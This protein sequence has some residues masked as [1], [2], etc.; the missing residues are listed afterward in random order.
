[1]W[2]SLVGVEKRPIDMKYGIKLKK[3]GDEDAEKKIGDV[4]LI[5]SK[6]L[7]ETTGISGRSLIHNSIVS[8]RICGH[9]IKVNSNY[10]GL[11]VTCAEGDLSLL[12]G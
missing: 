11:V 10:L 5:R 2:L 7:F 12:P 8:T 6:A 4:Y 1:M 3:E 9:R